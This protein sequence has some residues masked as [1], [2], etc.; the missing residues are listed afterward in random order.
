M[1]NDSH[2]PTGYKTRSIRFITFQRGSG[3]EMPSFHRVLE[4]TQSWLKKRDFRDES[5][6]YVTKN[7]GRRLNEIASRIIWEIECSQNCFD[8]I[9]GRQYQ[10][11]RLSFPSH[12][13]LYLSTWGRQLHDTINNP[14]LFYFQPSLWAI[15]P[16]NQPY[17]NERNIPSFIRHQY[18]TTPSKL[19]IE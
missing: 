18:L 19:I 14:W 4:A 13:I 5:T 6:E 12:L 9:V 11:W 15:L 7:I 1:A 3:A 17:N 8:F 2:V 16:E 10:R